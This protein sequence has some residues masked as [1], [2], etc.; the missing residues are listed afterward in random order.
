MGV[1]D[2][3]YMVRGGTREQCQR[4]L[5][6]L[7]RL[8]GARPTILPTDRHGAGWIARAV[9]MPKAPAVGEGPVER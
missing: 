2:V 9:S 7:C 6:E 5:D 8:V 4:A 1:S 3:S